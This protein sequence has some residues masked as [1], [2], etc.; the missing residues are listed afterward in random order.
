MPTLQNPIIA[1]LGLNYRSSLFVTACYCIFPS[2]HCYPFSSGLQAS[3]FIGLWQSIGLHCKSYDSA[4]WHLAQFFIVPTWHCCWKQPKPLF[5]G[6]YRMFTV[7]I[8]PLE[9]R[10]AHSTAPNCII[11]LISCCRK[12][13]TS[14][15]FQC[16]ITTEVSSACP[17][18]QQAMH[19][20]ENRTQ[21]NYES[22]YGVAIF[23]YIIFHIN[24]L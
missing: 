14:S 9:S 17:K 19:A 16:C 23:C 12:S 5:R 18:Q 8:E 2:S 20:L 10:S 3:F 21:R 1:Q 4:S 6:L 11:L 24:Y 7:P 22:S 15:S 13:E